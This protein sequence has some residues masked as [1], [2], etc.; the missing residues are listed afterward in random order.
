[1]DLKIVVVAVLLLFESKLMHI[2][3]Q[4]PLAR[5]TKSW[6]RTDRLSTCFGKLYDSDKE[7]QSW[8]PRFLPPINRANPT[9][10]IA[11]NA[12]QMDG[13]SV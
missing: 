8:F 6:I 9:K 1:M 11:G 3:L 10:T 12:N 5:I 4:L 7:A 13:I 2:V